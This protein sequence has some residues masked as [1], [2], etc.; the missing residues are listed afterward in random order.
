MTRILLTLASRFTGDDTRRIISNFFS[1]S[2]LQAANL[3]LPLIT[4]PYLVQVIGL[5]KFG[6]LSFATATIIY[7]ETLT[8][9][10]FDLSATRRISI[11]R[12]DPEQVANIFSAVMTIKALLA[13]LSLVILT[14]LVLLVE[15]FSSSM[16]VFYLTFG[17]VLGKILFPVWFFQGLEKMWIST[18]LNLTSKLLFVAGIFMFVRSEGDFALAAGFQSMGF[19]VS[20]AL[21]LLQ[22]RFGFG[23]RF[24][25]PSAVSLKE[26]LYDGWHIFISRVFVNL[27]TATNTILLGFFSGNLMVGQYTVA[28]KLLEAMSHFFGPLNDALFPYMS[29]L[30]Q[31]SR[32]RFHLLVRRLNIGYLVAGIGVTALAWTFGGHLIAWINGAPDQTITLLFLILSLRLLAMPFG[33]LYTNILINQNRKSEY[34]KVVRNTFIA[35][36]VLVPVGI[37]LWGTIGLGIAS[38]SVAA[39]HIALFLR[40]GLQPPIVQNP[41]DSIKT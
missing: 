8:D 23:V 31:D 11:C 38:V 39:V 2:V 36:L 19:V 34:L 22:I 25:T 35:N 3:L 40:Q 12:N 4:F 9:Y 24:R 26:H 6:L 7:F 16:L 20:G 29:R 13:L 37:C 30:Y 17:R 14:L 21:A 32:A 18:L 15:R 28:V 33:S 27:Y 10:G 1:L 5:E 41:A